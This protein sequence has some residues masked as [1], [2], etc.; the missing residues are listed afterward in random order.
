VV[1]APAP[2]LGAGRDGRLDHR[3]GGLPPLREQIAC[4]LIGGHRPHQ[5]VY[6]YDPVTGGADQRVSARRG[7]RIIGGQ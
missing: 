4:H 1:G 7:D 2:A 3:G 5:L 6:R